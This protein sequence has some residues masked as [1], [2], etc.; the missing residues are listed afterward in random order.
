MNAAQVTDIDTEQQQRKSQGSGQRDHRRA[1]IAGH[2]FAHRNYQRSVV[3]V[4]DIKS[5]KPLSD[6]VHS[7]LRR[8]RRHSRAQLGGNPI[9]ALRTFG[10]CGRV[11][12]NHGPDV[13]LIFWRKS[14]SWRSNSD[15]GM[16][17]SI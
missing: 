9:A 7:R 5:R 4:F 2:R 3:L 10:G 17:S 16:S 6:H 11:L 12:R 8:F 1:K 13:N 14:E 15:D